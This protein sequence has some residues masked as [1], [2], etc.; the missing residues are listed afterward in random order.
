MQL[1]CYVD[2]YLY[3]LALSVPSAI[4]YMLFSFISLS[5]EL[6]SHCILAFLNIFFFIFL[7]FLK[8]FLILIFH[9]VY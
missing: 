4:L 5:F 3:V 1:L 8:L 7:G 6:Y 2:L 9:F